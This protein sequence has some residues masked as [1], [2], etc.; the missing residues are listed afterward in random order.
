M[1]RT[2][3]GFVFSATLVVALMASLAWIGQTTVKAQETESAPVL[4]LAVGIETADGQVITIPL[5]IDNETFAALMELAPADDV[6]NLVTQLAGSELQTI[7]VVADAAFTP[8]ATSLLIQPLELL[9]PPSVSETVVTAT[10]PV[11][12]TGSET[13]GGY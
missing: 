4:E 8:V 5:Q 13:D 2:I 3:S 1:K 9:I 12:E 10:V 11:T 7:T 6:I